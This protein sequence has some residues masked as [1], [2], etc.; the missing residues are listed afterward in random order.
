M[1]F[2]LGQMVELKAD[3]SRKGSVIEKLQPVGGLHRYRVFHSAGNTQDYFENQLI[4]S[5]PPSTS[6]DLAI[7]LQNG[8]FTPADEFRAR[9]TAERLSNPQADSL[10]SLHAARIQFIPFQLK[11]LLRFLR[12]D[13]PRLLIADE[14]GVGKTIE[15]GLILR[16]M[17]TRQDVKNV[18]I[19]CPKA[20][21]SKW[22]AEMKRFDEDFRSI[23]PEILRYCI[24]ETNLDGEWPPQ[25][26][27]GIV[28][29]ELLRQGN[30][31]SGKNKDGTDITPVEPVLLTLDPPPRFSL[32]IIDE[33]HHLRNRE[34]NSHSAA[35]FLCDVSEAVLFLSATPVHLGSENLYTLLNLLRPDLLQDFTVFQQ[36]MEPNTHLIRSMR[37]IR[38]RMP[39][40]NWQ[41][42]SLSAVTDAINTEWGQHS[43][44]MDPRIIEWGDRLSHPTELVNEERIR[45][46]RDL[47]EVQ[48]F[49]HL[50]NR[51]RRRDIGQ[52]ALREPH[53]VEAPFTADQMTFYKALIDFRQ[54][55]LSL[56]YDPLIARLIIVN[57]ER[58]VAS[59]L[60]GLSPMLDNFIRTGRFATAEFTDDLENDNDVN[61]PEFLV[62]EAK[63]LRT[64]A[65]NLSSDDPK[66][67]RLKEI[68]SRVLSESRPQKVL[69]FSYFLHTL[70]YLKINLAKS[71]IRVGLITGKS[72]DDEVRKPLMWRF[73][74]PHDDP[75]AIDIL[76]SSEVGCEGLDYEFC[77]CLV[78][79]DIPWNP[80][81]IEQRI[82]RIDRFGQQ[83]D[84]VHIYNFI[85]P[86]TVEERIIFRC[87]E[88]L[89][90]FRNTV[91]DNEEILADLTK[92]LE[93]ITYE[94]ELSPE[95]AEVRAFQMSD[96]ALRKIEEQR[97]LEENS[98][99]LLGLENSFIEEVD[100]LI[101]E[102]RF[103][104]PD[105][106]AHMIKQYVQ[107][108]S[109]GGGLTAS[110]R[111]PVYH[112]LRLNENARAIVLS[113]LNGLN[114]YDR[115]T[116][117][118][119][120]WLGSSEAR[121]TLT[122]D[123]QTALE[124]RD[125]PFITPIHPLA[126]AAIRYWKDLSTPLVANLLLQDSRISS[127]A[128]FFAL[129]L[130][131][132]VAARSEV[133]LKSFAWDINSNKMSPALS[134]LLPVFEW[135]S[136]LQDLHRMQDIDFDRCLEAV[137]EYANSI[138][139]EEIE[140]L[141]QRNNS[142]LDRQLASLRG[143]Y[144]NRLARVETELNQS[145]NERIR[146]MRRSEKK[147]IKSEFERKLRE[148]E[149][150]RKCDIVVNRIAL[151]LIRIQPE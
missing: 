4:P 41:D 60:P 147:R 134:S 17:Q 141:K 116:A 22:Q 46:L 99:A 54:Q 14:V 88:R 36:M 78:N 135:A 112:Q 30:Y 139:L 136:D 13:Q 61:L 98:E 115:T 26:S 55:M 125:L 118:F 29:L 43:L 123:R 146:T 87:F 42:E 75:E 90:I 119:K 140:Q 62:E 31:L 97:R 68:I 143:Y 73:R 24:D 103:V 52:F 9:I 108:D 11:P 79:Y 150:Q 37:H 19:V 59:C 96:N 5:V 148:I 105:D 47:E 91:G 44:R 64:L 20:L 84:K 144:D 124:Q 72:D 3:P 66:L 76:L 65:S 122:F 151:G 117:D 10:Y 25:Y 86:G 127:G 33:A 32:V 109:V 113:H 89:D 126:K 128:Y 6:T 129:E 121:L 111:K 77:D 15:A 110:S 92:K 56:E 40:E 67:E 49:A 85:T 2:E 81:K 132:T 130:W 69:V 50:M 94:T 38:T 45:C 18:L 114:R 28:S 71:N 48:T 83:S 107:Q 63:I 131:E 27:R 93:K 58:Q 51:T 39:E 133:R 7:A 12:A 1:S 34:T 145:T 70:D 8:D 102:G 16:E 82:G 101:E 106:L 100:S 95:Q 138:R 74:L 23:T 80:M 57:F 21:V 149:K 120:R 137:D 53:T 142:L 104:S 35:R